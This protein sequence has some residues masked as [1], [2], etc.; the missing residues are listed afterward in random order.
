MKLLTF[1][2]RAES[3]AFLKSR[4]LSFKAKAFPFDGFYL[5]DKGLA[6]LITGEGVQSATEK[7]ASICGAYNGEITHIFNFGVAGIL[8]KTS[9]LE[10]GQIKSMRTCYLTKA[11]GIEFKSFT[12][13]DT[14]CDPIDCITSHKRALKKEDSDRLSPFASLVDRECWA[15]GSVANRFKIPFFATKILSDRVYESTE[16]GKEICQQVKEKAAFF[17]EAL[18]THFLK[19]QNLE[20][21]SSQGPFELTVWEKLS[22]KFGLHFTTSH[23]RKFQSLWD[24]LIQKYSKDSDLLRDLPLETISERTL[25]PKD[26]TS[27]LLDKMENLS[28]PIKSNLKIELEKSLIHLRE[29]KCSIKFSDNFENDSMELGL[30]INKASDLIKIKNALDKTDYQHIKNLLNGRCDLTSSN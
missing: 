26:K 19:T 29:I 6:L 14:S 12:T 1:A 16:E 10:I 15:I 5:S 18:L 21:E 23:K 13:S 28:S 8:E 7:L 30:K 9:N 3:Q 20:M 4:S 25:S 27:L 17:S 22:Q 24:V 11:E 2:H